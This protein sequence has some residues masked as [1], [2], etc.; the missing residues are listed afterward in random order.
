MAAAVLREWPGFFRPRFHP[1]RRDNRRESVARARQWPMSEDWA[2]PTRLVCECACVASRRSGAISAWPGRARARSRAAR[3]CPS[4]PCFLLGGPRIRAPL[5]ARCRDRP[6][7]FAARRHRENTHLAAIRGDRYTAQ[8][9]LQSARRDA[10]YF[11]QTDFRP[12]CRFKRLACRTSSNWQAEA[13]Y[14]R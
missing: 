11:I 12:I 14:Q 8:G 5:A 7:A 1:W 10:G 4:A 6:L 2:K 13:R 3:R 9:R